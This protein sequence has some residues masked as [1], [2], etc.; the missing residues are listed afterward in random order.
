M[1]S[2]KGTLDKYIGDAVMTLWN[3]PLDIAHHQYHAAIAALKIKDALAALNQQSNVLAI[4]NNA[5]L[6]PIGVRIGIATGL[7]TVG[8]MGSSQRFDYSALGEPVNMAARAEQACKQVGADIVI[9]GEL[10]GKSATLS[11]LDAG[12]LSFRGLTHKVQCHAVF[13]ASKDEAHKQADMALYSF[14]SGTRLLQPKLAKH[15]AAFIAALASRR[16]DY[17][18]TN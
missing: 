14:Q 7:A 8:N 2:E 4:L 9:A 12:K 5:K 1:Q 3:A 18:L 15:Y 10:I 13:G 6:P 11:I 17:G 16:A